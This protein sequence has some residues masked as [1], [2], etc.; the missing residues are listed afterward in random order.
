MAGQEFGEPRRSEGLTVRPVSGALGAMIEGVDLGCDLEN[1]RVVSGIHHA[2]LDH[3]VVFLL[4]QHM[5][6]EQH[7]ALGLKFGTLNVHD[8]VTI[9]AS[10]TSH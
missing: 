1:N 4:D 7:I 3:C 2:L 8:Y 5:T 9:A 6:P 10:S